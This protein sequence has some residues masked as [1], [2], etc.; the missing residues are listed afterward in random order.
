MGRPDQGDQDR[1]ARRSVRE[2]E[3]GVEFIG[4][5]SSRE[6]SDDRVAKLVFQTEDGKT[7]RR[8]T[9]SSKKY[10]DELRA[11]ARIVER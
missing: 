5:C 1:A 9:S 4:I 8:P 10:I 7:T 6:V 3:R 11:K 2:T